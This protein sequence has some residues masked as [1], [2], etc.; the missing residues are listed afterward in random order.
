MPRVARLRYVYIIV[1]YF[2][3]NVR[4]L[5][6]T[7]KNFRREETS[8]NSVNFCVTACRILQYLLFATYYASMAEQEQAG[9]K[10]IAPESSE[11]RQQDAPVY[12]VCFVV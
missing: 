3:N 6:P 9:V 11:P 10:D 2:K 1:T 8:T 4:P 12:K 7:I 5:P